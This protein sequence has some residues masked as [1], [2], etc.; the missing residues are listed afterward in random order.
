MSAGLTEA[1]IESLAI[2]WFRSLG[3]DCALGSEW[4]AGRAEGSPALERRPAVGC[5]AGSGDPRTADAEGALRPVGFAA[6]GN[7]RG[8][9]LQDGARVPNCFDA[10]GTLALRFNSLTTNNLKGTIER[11]CHIEAHQG[12]NFFSANGCFCPVALREE[13]GG[14]VSWWVGFPR[15]WTSRPFECLVVRRNRGQ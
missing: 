11:E 1:D 15:S 14:V 6:A 13:A 2:D 3:Y 4:V 9:T 12:G 5:C 8:K 10:V 7:K